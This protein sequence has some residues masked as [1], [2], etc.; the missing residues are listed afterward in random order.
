M[1]WYVRCRGCGGFGWFHAAEEKAFRE[2]IQSVAKRRNEPGGLSEEGTVE[3]HAIFAE[4]LPLCACG[5][6]YSVVRLMEQEP[7]LGCG[8]DLTGT[9]WPDPDQKKKVSVLRISPTP[10]R[11]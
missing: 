6:S 8:Q 5:T 7:C 1:I 4:S 9:S 10:S 11:S 2:A 3:A